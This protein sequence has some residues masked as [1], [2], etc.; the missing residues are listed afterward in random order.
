MATSNR[1][2]RTP[3]FVAVLCLLLVISAC[4]TGVPILDANPG[5]P[6]VMGTITGTVSG[7]DGSTAIAGRKVTAVNLDTSAREISTTSETGGY[8][9][10]VPAGRY[11]VEVELLTGEAVLRDTGE[12]KLSKS[13]LQH[14]VDIRIGTRRVPAASRIYQPP[15]DTGAPLA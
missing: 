5:P 1:R 2:H 14:D 8:T 7:E 13:E 12:F 4:R 15:L 10:K 3:H 9:F 6:E 11:R